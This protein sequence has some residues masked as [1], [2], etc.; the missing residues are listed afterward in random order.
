MRNQLYLALKHFMRCELL[1]SRTA[2]NF[3]QESMAH[4]LSMSTRAYTD[5]ESG[6][7]CC[8]LI[9]F[10]LFLRHCCADQQA[11]LNKLF[12]LLDSFESRV[13]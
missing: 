13:A 5:L 1:K 8:G 4:T 12:D 9:T 11:F 6:K 7:T 2:L 10:L 3:S